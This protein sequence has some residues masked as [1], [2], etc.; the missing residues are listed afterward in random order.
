MRG[1]AWAGALPAYGAALL[2]LMLPAVTYASSMVDALG[3]RVDTS[4]AAMRIVSLS[5]N[6]TEMLYAIGAGDRVVGVTRYCDFPPDAKTRPVVGGI[7]DPSIE[8]ILSLAPDLVTVTRGNPEAAIDQLRRA[9]LRVFAFDAQDGCRRVS[10]DMTRLIRLVHPAD[11]VAA[12]AKVGAFDAELDV[13]NRRVEAGT[14]S[15]PTVYFYDPASPDWTTGPG[16]HL[17]EAIELAG[18]RNLFDD[19]VLAWP[20]VSLDAVVGKQPEWILIAVPSSDEPMNVEETHAAWRDRLLAMPGWRGLNAVRQGRVCTVPAD[21]IMRPGPRIL[22]GVHRL[23]ACLQ[24][25]LEQD[26]GGTVRDGQPR[27]AVR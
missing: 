18:G 14:G 12:L 6:L 13:L 7:V 4:R 24:T 2:V 25:G 26:H 19:A 16:T 15:G 3:N 21:L 10:E 27:G 22:D 17:S 9:G 23:A 1:R 20:R 5:P 8:G 11:S